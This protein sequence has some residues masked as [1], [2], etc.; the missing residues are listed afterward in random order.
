MTRTSAEELLIT[1]YS[2]AAEV[3]RSDEFGAPDAPHLGYEFVGGSVLHLNGDEHRSRRR[4]EAPL[5]AK[6]AI[7]Q[8]EVDVLLAATSRQ[9]ERQRA[10]PTAGDTGPN[11]VEIARRIMLEVAAVFI[12]LDGA[13]DA[14]RLA[15]LERCMYPLTEAVELRWTERDQNEVIAQGLAAKAVFAQEFVDPAIRARLAVHAEERPADLIGLLVGTDAYAEDPDLPCREAIVFLAG[16][17]L[18]TSTA[19]VSTVLELERWFA[20]HP[21]DRKQIADPDFLLAATNETLRLE[22]TAPHLLKMAL[23]DTRLPDGRPVSAGQMVVIDRSA[24]H[25]DVSVFGEDAARF[26]PNRQVPKR[27]SPYG[28][29]FGGGKHQC[30]GKPLVSDARAGGKG[31]PQRAIPAVVAALYEHGLCLDPSRPARRAASEQQRY[32]VLPVTFSKQT[33]P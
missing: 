16:S 4:L 27:V 30:I 33:G 12:G 9:I 28:L 19:I 5:F 3:A 11:L 20:D 24:V 21:E 31:E 1:A 8:Y 2:D 32:D 10:T 15:L 22:P 23:V 14:D 25:R 6:S 29:A 7:L 17:T 18:S 13:D 26:N